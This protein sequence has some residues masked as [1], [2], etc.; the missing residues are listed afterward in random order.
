MGTPTLLASILSAGEGDDD[1]GHDTP[2]AASDGEL[3][4]LASFDVLPTPTC[5]R[6]VRLAAAGSG[7]GVALVTGDDFG[8]SV[9]RSAVGL[10]PGVIIGGRAPSW[11][12]LERVTGE[13]SSGA[14]I[15]DG[16]GAVIGALVPLTGTGIA[17]RPHSMLQ[18]LAELASQEARLRVDLDARIRI[19]DRLRHSTLHDALTGL[20][21]R[22]LFMERLSHA[23]ARSKRRKEYLFAVLFLDLDRFKVVNDSL[24]HQVGDE[25]LIAVAARL[26]QCLRTED[27]VARLGGDEFAILLENISEISDAGRIAERIQHELAAPVNLSGYEVFTSVSIGIVDSASAYGLPDYMLRSADMAMYRAKASG[28]ARYEMFD[29]RMHAQALARLQTETDLRRA[30]ERSEFTLHYQPIVALDTG[31]ICGMEALLRWNHPER[32]VVSPGEFIPVAE[33]TGLIVPIGH[34]V[35]AEACHQLAAW[36]RTRRGSGAPLSISV[37]LSVRQIAQTDLVQS[38]AAA[39]QKTGI[40]PESLKLEVTESV[41]VENPT[42]ATGVLNDL[43]ALGVELY[44]DDFGTGYSSLSY[45]SRLP[46]DAIKIDRSFVSQM[47]ALDRHFQLVRTV[48]TL[49]HTLNLRAVAEGVTTEAQMVALR[50][51]GC[52]QAQG[53]FFSPPVL[54][55][56]AA[57]LLAAADS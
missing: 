56:A 9:V 6:I 5:D 40:A 23:I 28:K 33:E 37:N 49:A 50:Q 26:Q 36:Q 7:A 32:G 24:G 10:P 52:E 54:P 8:N 57:A 47:D 41:I 30:L 27:T 38:V 35:L 15:R 39:L 21:N 12:E 3:A 18:E 4:P 17:N 34:W 29:R 46:I 22:T 53:Y 25:L 16:H 11:L 14:P 48:L 51:L 2:S 1:R 44:M 55:D 13:P 43:K 20:P 45:L 31:R 19:E 42:A